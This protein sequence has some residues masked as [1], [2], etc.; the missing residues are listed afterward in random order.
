M[1]PFARL[2]HEMWQTVAS[3]HRIYEPS[4]STGWLQTLQALLQ[5]LTASI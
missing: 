1:S 5:F 4:A 3:L 2:V